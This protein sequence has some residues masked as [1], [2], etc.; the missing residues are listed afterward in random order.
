MPHEDNELIAYR[1]SNLER[2][3]ADM[4]IAVKSIAESLTTLARLEDKHEETREALGRAFTEIE[5]NRLAQVVVNTDIETRTKKIEVEMPA[6]KMVRGWTI[7]GV[8][9]IVALVGIA[10]AAMVI[11]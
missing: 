4:A 6:L 2:N 9:G 5:K 7:T 3:T 10:V 1:L 8:L 11:H